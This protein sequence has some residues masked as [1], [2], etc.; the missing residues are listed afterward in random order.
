MLRYGKVIANIMFLWWIDRRTDRQ[1]DKVIPMYCLCLKRVAQKLAFVKICAI[2]SVWNKQLFNVDKHEQLPAASTDVWM[3]EH[4]VTMVT[5]QDPEP[6]SLLVVV[7]TDGTHVILLPWS[8]GALVI[9]S[10]R[11]KTV[12]LGSK[13]WN[14][15]KESVQWCMSWVKLTYFKLCM[16]CVELRNKRSVPFLYNVCGL[17]CLSSQVKKLS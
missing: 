8:S 5:G 17:K 14:Y 7:Q 13:Q 16:S 12:I 1:T 9:V 4:M 6:V 10:Q 15:A 2:A 11:K 3:W